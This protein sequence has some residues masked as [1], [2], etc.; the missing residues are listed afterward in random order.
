MQ[1]KGF[2]CGTLVFVILLLLL[3]GHP[4]AQAEEVT[5]RAA[6]E[7]PSGAR[8]TQVMTVEV[9]EAAGA[10]VAPAPGAAVPPATPIPE[11]GTLVL[12]GLGMA[13]VLLLR[14]CH[15]RP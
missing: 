11:P 7:S 9:A 12:V 14:K 3:A 10:P 8:G 2:V 15:L 13:G 6:F 1:H 5:R 4:A